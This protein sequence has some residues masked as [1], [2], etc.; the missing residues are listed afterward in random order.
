MKLLIIRHGDPDYTIDSL[1]EKGWREAQLLSKRISKLDVK[2]FYCSPLGRAKDT[3][4][5]TLKAMGR[6]A[7]ICDWLMEFPAVITDPVTKEEV[8][9]WDRKPKEWTNIHDNYSA[10]NWKNTD[11]IKTGNSV[12]LYNNVCASLDELFEKHGY[13]RDGNI[14]KAENPNCDTVV[15]FCHFGIEC[16]LLSHLLGIS[17]M[18]LWHNFVA[19]PTSVTTLVTE[20]RDEG[21]A[22]FRCI[23]FG[24]LSHLY[25]ADEPPAFAA[26]FCEQYSNED[27]RH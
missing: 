4:S 9:P 27:E 23:S 24:D 19:L 13:K 18:V 2:S 5:P 26:R 15:F 11:I 16:V 7:E 21:I 12:E 17:P 1:T 20:E 14:Y 10:D 25:A 22:S 6:N 3:A 8:I